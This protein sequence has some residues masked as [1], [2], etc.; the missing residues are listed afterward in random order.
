[1]TRLQWMPEVEKLASAVAN[2]R[3]LALVGLD[4]LGEGRGTIVRVSV[5]GETG[6][7]VEQCAEVA[8]ELGRALDLHD[9]IPHGY[10]LEVASPGLDRPLRTGADFQR[11]AGRRIEVTMYEAVDGRRRWKGRLV[12]LEGD[13]VVLDVDAQSARLPLEGI[14]R[15]HLV[16]EMDD[17][18]EDFT[19]G[20]R[21]GP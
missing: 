17:L 18:R 1:M 10:T 3:G 6:V 13:Q 9:P 7:S 12:G 15:A 11:F 2:R 20:G 19:K 8:E 14:A 21:V 4:V 16:V 5:E